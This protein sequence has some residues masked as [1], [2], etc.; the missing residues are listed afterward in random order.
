M[1]PTLEPSPPDSRRWRT[2]VRALAV[3]LVFAL[4]LALRLRAA[5]LLPTDFDEDDYLRAGQL[6]AQHLAA[7]DWS[8]VADER[9]NYEH[10]PLTKLA[11]GA[12]LLREGP[13]SYAR[14]VIALK[15]NNGGSPIIAQKARGLRVFNA[16]VGALTAAVV[17]VINPLAGLL[18]ALNSWH[19]KY[20]SQA[21]LEALPC[22]LAALTALLLRR[23]RR[24]GDWPFW[25]AAVA[26]GMT[27]A[28]KYLYAV[29]GIAGL[30]W[31]I[32]RERAGLRRPACWARLLGWGGLALLIFYICD[33]A[34]WPDPLGRLS[35]SLRFSTRYAASQHVQSAGFGWE[36][37]IYWLL[38]AVP[39]H[40]GVFPLLLDGLFGA[41]GLLGLRRAWREQRLVALWFGVMLLFL[42]IWPTKWPQYILTVTVP[43]SLIAS[44]QIA[45]W[46]RRA[47]A[48]WRTGERSH[49]TTT[50]AL[51]LTPI[52]L[53]FALLVAYPLVI[54]SALAMSNFQPA[55]LRR[56]TG[57]LLADV[58]RG[59]LSLEPAANATAFYGTG[60]ALCPF[61]DR[62]CGALNSGALVGVLINNAL[63]VALTVGL[64][65]LLALWLA[66]LLARRGLRGRRGWLT[67]FILPWA[68]PEFVGAMLWGTL[69]EDRFGAV[70][71]ML[72]RSESPI[73]WLSDPA[74]VVDVARLAA[75]LVGALN[76]AGLTPLGGLLAVLSS[77][78]TTTKAF[79]V[80]ALVGVWVALPFMLL[81]AITA[82]RSVPEEVLDA[83]RVDGAGGWALWRHITWPLVRPAIGSGMLLRGI[84]LFNAF[85]I[86]LLLVV[87]QNTRTETIALLAYLSLRYNNSYA[88]AARLS[89]FALLA[90]MALV[91]WLGRR[92]RALDAE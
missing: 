55:N 78:L 1:K 60:A 30:I 86:P 81:I 18:V 67:L 24:A 62:G 90:V 85:H 50:L 38:G 19:I 41:V 42:L 35:E 17:A 37:P 10:P 2:L 43:I 59:A 23:S 65:T 63:W 14:P 92:E 47:A 36:Q 12:I 9:E 33:P 44:G 48:G 53:F 73:K 54:Q 91:W 61:D 45:G 70:N 4:A 27:A 7:G 64:A 76:R 6:Y 32:W 71:Y 34:L 39:W 3:A 28:G 82:L 87:G 8:A 58:G 75:P 11:Y 13:A 21:M 25:L 68:I 89:T 57:G 66:R 49:S 29:V 79:W 16:V 77:A 26:L 51:W 46:W 22:L 74:P 15:D 40:P 56:G 88:V 83:A 20:T 69:F 80:M 52:A 5:A 31:L 72:G 84:L